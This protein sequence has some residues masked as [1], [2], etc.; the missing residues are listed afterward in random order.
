MLRFWIAWIALILVAFGLVFPQFVGGI[1]ACL[2]VIGLVRYCGTG[3]VKARL[4]LPLL[5]ILGV[6]FGAALILPALARFKRQGYFEFTTAN[7]LAAGIL[8]VLSGLAL[9]VRSAAESRGR[10]A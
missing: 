3:A 9:L 4:M 1:L 5:G 6:L 10:V 8:I 7:A 2:A